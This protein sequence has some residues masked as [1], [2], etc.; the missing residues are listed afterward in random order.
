MRATNIVFNIANYFKEMNDKRW[1]AN[2]IQEKGSHK[3]NILN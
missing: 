2:K 1:K 3:L